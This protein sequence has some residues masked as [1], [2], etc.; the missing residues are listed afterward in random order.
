MTT[1]NPV[2]LWTL[3]EHAKEYLERV[4]SISHRGEGEAAL[5]EFIP[6]LLGIVLLRSG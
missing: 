1:S 4:D 3:K 6:A 5:L 2:N